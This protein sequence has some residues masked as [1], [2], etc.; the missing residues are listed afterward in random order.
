MAKPKVQAR[1]G[2]IAV[3]NPSTSGFSANPGS[4]DGARPPSTLSYF[5]DLPNISSISNPHVVVFFRNLFK[6]DSTTK[7]RALED[8]QTYLGEHPQDIEDPV[9]DAWV[10]LARCRGIVLTNLQTGIYPRTSI[11]ASRRVRQLAH[12]IQGKVASAVGKRI[13]KHLPSSIGPWLLGL[14]DNDKLVSKAVKAG[15]EQAFPAA[16]KQKIL[17]NAF[18]EHLLE[19]SLN[20]IQ[21]ESPTTL[22][23]E[24]AVGPAEAAA[25]YNRTLAASIRLI[26]DLLEFA[27]DEDSRKVVE[28]YKALADDQKL[29]G[30]VT[31]EDASVR[32]GIHKLV[33]TC[34]N[35][36]A[37]NKSFDAG[38]L[39]SWYVSKGLESE[40]IGS[41]AEFL[42]TLI[43]LTH[44]YPSIWTSNWSGTKP[45]HV[46]LRHFLRKGSQLGPPT[47]WTKLGCML[48][49]LPKEAYPDAQDGVASLLKA[50]QSGL[51]RKEEPRSYLAAGLAS[52]LKAFLHSV[53]TVSSQLSLQEQKAILVSTLEPLVGSL[54]F[55]TD[56]RAWDI[57]EAIAADLL[58]DITR[59]DFVSPALIENWKAISETLVTHIRTLLPATSSDHD[60]SQLHVGSEAQRWA[61][62]TSTLCLSDSQHATPEIIRH[63]IKEAVDV[64]VNRN[65]RAY[66]AAAAIAHI[67]TICKDAVIKDPDTVR[68]L[69]DFLVN[70]LPQIFLSLSTSKLALVMKSLNET[71]AFEK[72]W[73]L[74]LAKIVEPVNGSIEAS[75]VRALF[76]ALPYYS[77]DLLSASQADIQNILLR[78]VDLALDGHEP[79]DAVLELLEA[80]GDDSLDQICMQ[81]MTAALSQPSERTKS[82][83]RGFQ[84]LFEQQPIKV[85]QWSVGKES[86]TFVSSVLRLT[87]IFNDDELVQAAKDL[88][89]LISS[90]VSSTASVFSDGRVAV[91]HHEL[92]AASIDSVFV[93]TL[94]QQA[95]NILLDRS[96]EFL[97]AFIPNLSVWGSQM[98][99]FMTKLDH[100]IVSS[101]KVA[102]FLYP[103]A[104]H[105]EHLEHVERDSS[106]F[107][108]PIRMAVYTAQLLRNADCSLIDEDTMS[109]VL[110]LLVQTTILAEQKIS[111][112][113]ANA[114]WSPHTPENESDMVEFI[115]QSQK[116]VSRWL[117]SSDW[118]LEERVS[119]KFLFV[120]T[121]ISGLFMEADAPTPYAYFSSRAFCQLTNELINI[122]GVSTW[123]TEMIAEE[124][125]AVRRS[126]ILRLQIECL[127]AYNPVLNSVPFA[128]R[129][130]NEM[131]A[132]LT[133][134]LDFSGH[135]DSVL[136]SLALLQTVVAGQHSS[137]V[138]NA[139]PQ[140]LFFLVK[141]LAEVLSSDVPARYH[142]LI[143]SIL[144][145]ILPSL[146]NSAD[147]FWDQIVCFCKDLWS[148]TQ[149]LKLGQDDLTLSLLY[150]SLKVHGTLR[151]MF[152]TEG[153]DPELLEAIYQHEE[154]LYPGL[155]N[156]MFLERSVPD[157]FHAPLRMVNMSISH[158]LS[159]ALPLMVPEPAPVMLIPILNSN[160]DSLQTC[161]FSR[162]HAKIPIDQHSLSVDAALETSAIRL[163]DELLSL[164]LSS[165][166]LRDVEDLELDERLPLPLK[167]YFLSWIL[168]FDHFEDAVGNLSK[169]PL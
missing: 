96:V 5:A 30:N 84:E 124:L 169:P 126:H 166:N 104:V 113:S 78:Y 115:S 100:Y 18:Q 135:D 152:K 20:I 11:D 138:N 101:P 127:S 39:S 28:K 151:K 4:S 141:A 7:A 98:H 136:G 97:P 160:S 14:H 29:W 1:S 162:L 86:L 47:F 163:P 36:P 40:Q 90:A 158:E 51:T 103:A 107:S 56:E 168:V 79:W 72:S 102:A 167:G 45:P 46:N 64:S 119:S 108:I 112:E 67:T 123:R 132:D 95:D 50:F 145:P 24:P 66:G 120:K 75:D 48:N 109:T 99:R 121:A 93:T 10:R 147:I 17:R 31:S 161:A 80:I 130:Y 70:D 2:R 13:L 153:C 156:L 68:I 149:C 32:R 3:G 150:E 42:E 143:L 22:S 19:F 35:N 144:N 77:R 15:L 111:V 134:S 155:F 8:L 33:R 61:I 142:V 154:D 55:V 37:M 82:A 128:K 165:S 157:E 9:L 41:A 25:K 44:A 129:W 137:F 122:H 76:K 59:L 27:A 139:A 49:S 117:Q 89:V 23:Y 73:R 52:G 159:G 85:Q 21:H 81:N 118:W 91:I 87:E 110:T 65:G 26:S 88:S 92:N 12:I 94:V 71:S 116:L 54:L 6:K 164:L 133:G 146:L 43:Y 34:L 83:I 62:A 58:K 106:G 125:A 57:P 16:E 105:A 38:H 60:L 63:V 114:L 131:V 74:C 69:E 53:P 148:L 140:R